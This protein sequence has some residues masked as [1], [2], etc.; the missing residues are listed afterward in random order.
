DSGTASR[1]SLQAPTSSKGATMRTSI[2]AA[3]PAVCLALGALVFV[4][5]ALLPSVAEAQE[6][7]ACRSTGYYVF[8]FEERAEGAVTLRTSRINSL[9]SDMEV[10]ANAHAL[11][12]KSVTEAKRIACSQAADCFVTRAAGFPQCNAELFDAV[13]EM[14][15]M[16]E[17]VHTF[18]RE[19]A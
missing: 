11:V 14:V 5:A 9:Q 12:W 18:R 15:R 1:L 10:V 4:A 16:P 17:D 6:R 13:F 2:P 7:R 19:V 8:S 3:E